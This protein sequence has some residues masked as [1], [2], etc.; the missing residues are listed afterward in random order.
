MLL[1]LC[2]SA[3]GENDWNLCGLWR[4]GDTSLTLAVNVSTG[5]HALS[6]SANR[7]SLS[8]AGQFTGHCRRFDVIDLS[9][10]FG[11]DPAVDTHFCLFWEPSLDQLK[12]K[13]HLIAGFLNR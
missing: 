11:L 2:P 12:L 4:H 10:Q 1:L 3:A 7:S 9:K 5:C 8:I 13:V 6:V